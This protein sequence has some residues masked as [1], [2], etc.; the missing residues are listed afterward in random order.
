MCKGRTLSLFSCVP[1]VLLRRNCSGSFDAACEEKGEI[2][3]GKGIVHPSGL[4]IRVSCICHA[5]HI[6]R[7]DLHLLCGCHRP[8]L[9]LDDRCGHG[10]ADTE[11]SAVAA[12]ISAAEAGQGRIR[13]RDPVSGNRTD[14]G[15]GPYGRFFGKLTAVILL[16]WQPFFVYLRENRGDLCRTCK[17]STL[18]PSGKL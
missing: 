9:G 10:S 18:L 13:N 5:L 2:E 1:Y 8:V 7:A 17:G 16:G 6:L 14:V 15:I 11:R 4:S 12:I 3:E